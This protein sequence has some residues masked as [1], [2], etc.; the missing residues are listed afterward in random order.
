MVA[1]PTQMSPKYKYSTYS[2][3]EGDQPVQ[4]MHGAHGLGWRLE[5]LPSLERGIYGTQACQSAV[6]EPPLPSWAEHSVLT[7]APP[8]CFPG[9][10]QYEQVFVESW[11]A[12]STATLQYASPP[13]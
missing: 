10:P 6:F 1:K 3:R 12:T 11:I 7:H 8:T 4:S 5:C 2:I 13:S 9:A